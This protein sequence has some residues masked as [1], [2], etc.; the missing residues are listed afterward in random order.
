MLIAPGIPAPLEL[1]EMQ[2]IVG[3]FGQKPSSSGYILLA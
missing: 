3:T 1:Q 2:S